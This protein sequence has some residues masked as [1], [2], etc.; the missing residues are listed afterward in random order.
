MH[1]NKAIFVWTSCCAFLFLLIL[2][3]DEIVYWNWFIIFIPMWSFDF[4][5]FTTSILCMSRKFTHIVGQHNVGS[6]LGHT[7]I[8]LRKHCEYHSSQDIVEKTLKKTDS[9]ESSLNYVLSIV[10]IFQ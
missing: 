1:M 10:I 4:M 5:L 2:K 8:L 7:L 3:L 9:T 6:R